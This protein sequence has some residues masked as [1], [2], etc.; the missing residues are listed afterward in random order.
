[1]SNAWYVS[2]TYWRRSLRESARSPDMTNVPFTPRCMK[3]SV[4]TA[5]LQELDTPRAS[6]SRP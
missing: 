2:A 3:L 6:R 1:M 5:A 4:L